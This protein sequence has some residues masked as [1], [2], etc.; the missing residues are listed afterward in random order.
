[1]KIN[2]SLLSSKIHTFNFRLEIPLSMKWMWEFFLSD[3]SFY[4]KFPLLLKIKWELKVRV[5][6]E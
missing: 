3:I 6:D 4:E 5:F 2:L 1:M